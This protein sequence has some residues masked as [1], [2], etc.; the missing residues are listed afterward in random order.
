VLRNARR[1]TCSG[2]KDQRG[3]HSSIVAQA[4]AGA[5]PEAPRRLKPVLA[6]YCFFIV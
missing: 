4:P 3:F 6:A 5:G 1:R 2:G